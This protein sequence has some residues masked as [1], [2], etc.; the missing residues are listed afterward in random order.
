[1]TFLPF[2]CWGDTVEIEIGKA[3]CEECGFEEKVLVVEERGI[4]S[5]C[6]HC[7]FIQWEWQPGDSRDYIRYLAEEN[8]A[9][10][11]DLIKAMATVGETAERGET[12]NEFHTRT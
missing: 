8:G 2:F 1:M 3:K 11:E 6:K 4:L 5:K 9:T 10:A 12:K 7:G